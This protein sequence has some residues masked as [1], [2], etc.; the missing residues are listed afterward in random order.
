MGDGRLWNRAKHD[1]RDVDSRAARDAEE[2][3]RRAD[4]RELDKAAKPD[5]YSPEKVAEGF[6][7]SGGILEAAELLNG[8]TPL[9]KPAR[10]GPRRGPGRPRGRTWEE[11][12]TFP[13]DGALVKR[14]DQEAE[15][16]CTSR[17]AVIRKLLEE[18]LSAR[19]GA[20]EVHA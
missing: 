15:A 13:A 8:P 19:G 12:V 16:M 20:G 14:L 3:S 11:K 5:D 1:H 2:H 10:V 18:A 9:L 17:S 6:L 4:D 7:R